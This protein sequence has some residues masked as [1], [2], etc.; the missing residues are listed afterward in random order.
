MQQPNHIHLLGETTPNHLLTPIT[1]N[2]TDGN[3]MVNSGSIGTN[4]SAL[5]S[6]QTQ[7]PAATAPNIVSPTPQTIQSIQSNTNAHHQHHHHHH[8]HEK[9]SKQKRHRTRFTPQQLQELERSFGK[10]HYPDIF[11]REELAMRIGLTESRVQVCLN[12]KNYFSPNN[13]PILL[14][15]MFILHLSTCQIKWEKLSHQSSI[16]FSHDFSMTKVG[17]NY[18]FT[19]PKF[20]AGLIRGP[21]IWPIS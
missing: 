18:L 19:L 5:N 14:P 10:T 9:Q 15:G 12:Y 17:E 6:L 4:G 13:F 20:M 1:I 2:S 21:A 7:L 11:M 16:C 8:H 3:S